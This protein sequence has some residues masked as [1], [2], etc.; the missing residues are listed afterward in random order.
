MTN[1]RP[2]SANSSSIVTRRGVDRGVGRGC[3][4]ATAGIP[5]VETWDLTPT[6][7]DMLVGFS[8]TA[9]AEAVCRRLHAGGRRRL[10][11]IGADNERALRRTAAFLAA[12]RSLRR[13]KP[14]V[15]QVAAPAMLDGGR[16][17]LRAVLAQDLTSTACSA[18][19]ICW[20]WAC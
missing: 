16:S 12:A 1:S 18:A 3:S 9:V 14:A 20:P 15:F 11:V 6:P 13:P 5:V 19:P 4:S 2:F 10:A 17:G 8:H 7:I